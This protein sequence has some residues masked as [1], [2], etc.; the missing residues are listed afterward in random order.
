MR[1]RIVTATAAAVLAISMSPAVANAGPVRIDRVQYDS[2][3]SDR[4]SNPSLNA[5]WVVIKNFGNRARQ[6]RGW[7]LRDK[8]GHVY[9]FGTFRLRP[10]RSVKVHTGSGRNSRTD[11]YWKQDWYVW[12]NDGDK[13]TLK[14][15][16]GRRADTC[17]WGDGPGVT[18]C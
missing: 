13:A 14:N 5:E 4:G 15:K 6:L 7:T 17:S 9:R 16:S 11:R 10:G 18:G 3:G 2:P 8:A 1:H 12:N